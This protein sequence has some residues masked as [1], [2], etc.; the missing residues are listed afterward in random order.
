MQYLNKQLLDNYNLEESGKTEFV[1]KE[2][3]WLTKGISVGTE[4]VVSF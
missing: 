1:K 4:L 3:D 2:D